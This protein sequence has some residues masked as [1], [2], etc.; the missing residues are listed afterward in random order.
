MLKPITLIAFIA[1]TSSAIAEMS[2]FVGNWA[3]EW[4]GCRSRT[5]TNY[6]A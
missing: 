6:A 1:A 3:G 4:D 2:P 5:D